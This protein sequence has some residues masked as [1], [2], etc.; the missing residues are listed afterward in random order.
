MVL[1]AADAFYA[2]R[3]WDN[4]RYFAAAPVRQQAKTI[5]WEDLKALCHPSWVKR[6]YD[7]DLCI[8]LKCGAEI[9]CVGLDAPARIEGSPWDGGIVDEYANCRPGIFDAHIRPM[10]ADRGGWLWFV[11]VPD[12]AG[13]AQGEYAEFVRVAKTGEDTEWAAYTWASA[14]ILPAA[15]LESARRRMDPRIYRQE[16][17]GEFVAA[18]GRAFPDFSID[19]HVV[20]AIAY[21][22]GV[23]IWWSLDFNIATNAPMCS[24][25]GQD[26]GDRTHVIAELELR[27]TRTGTACE[28]FWELA[29]QRGWDLRGLR[30]YGDA[31]GQNRKTT[32]PSDWI[33][34]R[35][36]LR[37]VP[38]LD[39]R[40]RSSN[41]AIRDTVNSIN[42]RLLNAAG[43][44]RL[45]M[46]R[47]CRRLTRDME[48]A[49]WP[50]DLTAQHC[51][52]ALRYYVHTEY[53]V[54]APAGDP[55]RIMIG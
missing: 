2:P 41:P 54:A 39:Y 17:L 25:V 19:G 10:L 35:Q 40:V 20:D 44:R 46:H 4:P 5:Y 27:D 55:G 26:W 8:R 33:V 23:P 1:A 34:V 13:P 24:L 52:A 29:Q 42:A 53:P 43:E 15:E 37:D 31:S 32:G 18:G 22:P 38:D 28:A 30:V 50:S 16:M 3:P 45:L 51:L 21:Q 9:W 7:G 14:D 12:A 47:D 11:G 6:I 49:I 48:A 36:W